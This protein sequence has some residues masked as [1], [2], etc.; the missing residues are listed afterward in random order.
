T[1]SR[2]GGPPGSSPAGS[3]PPRPRPSAGGAGAPGGGGGGR[4]G[5]ARSGGAGSRAPARAPARAAAGG[6]GGR[7]FSPAPPPPP[8]SPAGPALPFS[9]WAARRL[10]GRA[11]PGRRGRGGT[12]TGDRTPDFAPQGAPMA[13]KLRP[14]A[15]Q[16]VAL[17]R[18]A[19]EPWTVKP[20]YGPGLLSMLVAP[21][22]V[23]KS[24]LVYGSL[25][26]AHDGLDFCGLETT[27]P[28]RGPP[29]PGA[30]E[31]PLPRPR[32]RRG[33]GGVP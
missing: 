15:A 5:G 16:R 20:L 24:E 29:L 7:S 4:W 27:R 18:F 31:R 19:A 23:G 6:G 13:V 28:R 2:C 17:A 30:A 14:V 21:P 26:A 1:R 33:L 9:R 11:I 8:P 3:T 32:L 22:G 10:V 25:G 12:R